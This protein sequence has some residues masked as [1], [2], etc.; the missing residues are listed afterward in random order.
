MRLK[1]TYARAT[2]PAIDI[3]VTTDATATVGDL[4][5][6]LLDSDPLA[7]ESQRFGELVT[8]RVSPAGGGRHVTVPADRTL[9]EAGLASGSRIEVADVAASLAPGSQGAAVMRILSGPDAPREVRLPAGSSVI[10]RDASADVVVNDPYIS[11]KHARVDVGSSI[12]LVDLNS[13]NGIT[14]DGGVVTR[15]TILPGQ[16]VSLGDSRLSFVLTSTAAPADTSDVHAGAVGFNRSPRVEDRYPEQEHPRPAVPSEVEDQPFPWL[17]LAAPVLMGIGMYAV[18]RNPLSLMFIA[19]A[20]LM[21]MGNHVTTRG[22]SKRQLASDV[23]RFDRQLEVLEQALSGTTPVERAVR[24]AEAPPVADVHS[25]GLQRGELLWTR[26]PEH[27]NFL[28]VRI[29]LGRLPSRNTIAAA[30]ASDDGLP[31]HTQRLEELEERYRTIDEVPVIEDLLTSGALGIVGRGTDGADAARGLLVQLVGLHSPAELVVTA[32]CAPHEVVD[33]AWLAWLPH[34]S[35]P[36]SPISGTHLADSA[37]TAAQLLAQLEELVEQR[38][39]REGLAPKGPLAAQ[40]AASRTGGLLG[41]T[42]GGQHVVPPLPVVVVVI[43]AEAPADP[44][45]LVQLSERA[46]QAGVVPLWLAP[47]PLQLPA[48]CRTWVDVSEGLARSSV[49]FVRHGSVVAPT[50]TEGVSSAHAGEFAMALAPLVDAGALVEDAS[51][52]PRNVPL[53]SLLGD[54]I[55][56]SGSAVVDR[57]R[58]NDSLHGGESR[59]RRARAGS[60]RALV[61][62]SGIDA[63]HLDLRSQGP[64]ALVGGTTGAGKSEFLQA[65]VLGMAAEFS[66]DRVT[67]LFVDYKGGAA[68]AECVHLPHCVG[69]FTD[70]NSHLVRRAL[71]SLRAELRHREELLNAKKAKDLIELEKRG[72]P[73]APP[74]LVLVIDEFAALAN[75]IPEF[76]DG[77]I[78]IAQRGRSLGIHLIMATQRPAGVIKDNLRANTNLRIAL[79]MADESDSS[80]VIGTPEAAVIDPDLPGRGVAKTGPGRL[81]PFQ[82]AYA[83]GRTSSEPVKPSVT[84]HRLGFGSDAPW[85]KLEPLVEADESVQGPTDQVRLVSAID[86]GARLAQVAAPRRPWLDEL[87]VAYDLT[88]LGPRTDTELILGV[89]DLPAEQDQ[90]SVHFR[91]DV[92]GNLAIYGT[93]GSGKSVLLRT[94]AAGAGVTPRGGPVEV[95]ALDFAAG[96]LRMLEQLPHVGAVIGSDDG[97]RVARLFRMLRDIADRRARDFPAVNASTITEYRAATGRA[98][99]PRIL[100]LVDGFAAFRDQWEVG[101]GRAEWY[102]VF[103]SLLSEG[104][105]LGIHVVFTAD[106]PASVPGS[107][108]SS[109]PRRVVLRLAE[110]TMYMSLDVPSDIVTAS[111]PPGRSVVD[112]QEVQLAILGGSRNAS[113]QAQALGK[114]ARAMARQ[115]RGAAAPVDVL[116]TEVRLDTLPASVDGMPVLGLSDETLAPVGLRPS[117]TFL[118]GGGPQS[119]RTTALSALV[120]SI[121]RWDPTTTMVYLGNRR[122][123]LPSLIDWDYVAV[124]PSDVA[125]LAKDLAG[126]ISDVTHDKY[127]VVVEGLAEMASSPTDTA[128]VDLVRA[129]KRSDHLVIAESESSSWTSSFPLYAEFKT[130]RRGLLLQ[131]DS[132][133]GDAILRTP[134]PRAARREFP[135][136]RGFAVLEGKVVRV[137]MPLL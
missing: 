40:L 126:R 93:G 118:I 97:E 78:D 132:H 84:I 133:E 110:E 32:L 14:V 116:P 117:G 48:V 43:T 47:S 131:P 7:Q 69:L 62:A 91:P 31:D 100:L 28:H 85:E 45:R 9:G 79:R 71:T 20:P 70:L 115:G 119:G 89:A 54:D 18:T 10:G 27:W 114:L 108:A 122:S 5:R 134:F 105:Q 16:E 73:E 35:S 90:R 51:D 112:G 96:G 39:G 130:G 107:V 106:R 92:D 44:A 26:R 3:A 74:A 12:E 34:T 57:W 23:A 81:M 8:L 1:L 50:V 13:A 99:E 37:A 55:A 136:G 15:L 38:L 95:Y 36:Q 60:L 83:G 25:A 4:A 17:L 30:G 98:G 2:G 42:D 120:R 82:S 56:E 66:P 129:I 121:R 109:V 76:V 113:D 137:Q 41:E 52:L 24:Q 75:E 94:L 29:G 128:L 87:G 64:H 21:M 135:T 68:F 88:I 46:A 19:M 63:M 53:V 58:Q 127:V 49:H 11:K 22:R 6:D 59:R 65:W 67:F 72:D 86:K 125:E 104:R 102:A 77:V 111:S 124:T 80:D 33:H 123:G 101:A 61:G 103:Q